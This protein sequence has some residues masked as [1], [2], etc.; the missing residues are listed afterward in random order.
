MS[1]NNFKLDTDSDG[2]VTMTIDVPNQ[3]MNVWTPDF[4]NE[5]D[6]FIDDYNSNDEM[7]G[8]V[9]TSGKENAF[10]AGADLNMMSE[11]NAAGKSLTKEAFQESRKLTLA[12]RKMEN[13]GWTTRQIQRE[14]KKAKPAAA[15]VEGLALGG[16]LEMCLATHQRFVADNPKIK[17]GLPKSWSG[18]SPARAVRSAPCG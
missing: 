18:S 12:L 17:L 6:K 2:I 1:Y 5:F 15:A 14:G 9:L 8:L 7:K 16:G 13:G 10:L 4:I 11:H 3:T